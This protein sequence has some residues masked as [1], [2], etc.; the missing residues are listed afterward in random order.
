M[1]SASIVAAVAACL[2]CR[3]CGGRPSAA[4]R[5]VQRDRSAVSSPVQWPDC[6]TRAMPSSMIAFA[7][8][9]RA[10]HSQTARSSCRCPDRRRHVAVQAMSTRRSGSG[11]GIAGVIVPGTPPGRQLRAAQTT[12]FAMLS[13]R[14]GSCPPEPRLARGA[15]RC[16]IEM[17]FASL[18]DSS[19]RGVAVAS[20]AAS[21]T[22]SPGWPIT[23]TVVSS[24]TRD[25][26]ASANAPPGS[27]GH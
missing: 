7:D 1:R 20:A 10:D 11:L 15:F 9:C 23:A 19:S 2:P 27:V 3:T 6:Q 25:A 4:Q 12:I 8:P 5:V 17:S 13:S 24:M 16:A 21:R 22:G 18:V 14:P 26:A